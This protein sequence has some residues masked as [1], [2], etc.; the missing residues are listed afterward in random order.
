MKRILVILAGAAALSVAIVAC[1]TTQQVTAY[2]SIN[3]VEQ[4]ATL[5]VNDYFALVIK[6]T[7]PTNGVPMVAKAYNDLQAAGALAA[8]ASQAGGN[9]L[10][11]SN[12]VVEAS[13]LGALITALETK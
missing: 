7:V 3:T 6:G 4:T 8:A 12:L 10:A 5:A 2:N 13:S 1:T 9:A 11:A